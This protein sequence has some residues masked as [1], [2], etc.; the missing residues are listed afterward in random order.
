MAFQVIKNKTDDIENAFTRLKASESSQHA[1][2]MLAD[3]LSAICGKSIRVCTISPTMKNQ[4]C[5][6]MSVYP[7]ESVL[8]KLITAIIA[9]ETEDVVK[10]IWNDSTVWNIEIDTRILSSDVDL[11]EKELTALILHEVGHIIDSGSIPSRINTIAKFQIAKSNMVNKQLLKDT[12]FSKVLYIP[13]MGACSFNRN[14][15]S[16]RKEMRADVYA[17][18]YGYAKELNSAMDKIIAYAGT[19]TTQ[20]EEL[21]TLMGFSIDTLT[22]FEKRKA[23]VVF[24][25][26]TTLKRSTHS[27]YMKGV[28]TKFHNA[29]GR[30]VTVP[31]RTVSESYTTDFI[32]DRMDKI[33]NEMYNSKEIV[34]SFFQFTRKMRRIDPAELDYIAVEIQ[35]IRTTDDKMMVISYI[36]SKLDIVDYYIQ[37]IDSGSKNYIIPHTKADLENIRKRLIAHRNDAMNAKVYHIRDIGLNINWPEGYEG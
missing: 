11:T 24:R 17:V 31:N 3:A 36:H 6:V 22:S 2:N 33:V 18:K 9:S 16:L 12:F 23:H 21:D 37:L 35:N 4:T 7:D 32:Y 5:N 27:P 14:S 26:L 20:D 19:D 29:I 13:I 25:D 15:A 8:D 28:L 1:C 10:K 34:E 30:P